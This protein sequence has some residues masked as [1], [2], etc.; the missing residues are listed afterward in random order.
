MST[1]KT[2]RLFIISGPSGVGK[3]SLLKRLLANHENLRFS[4]SSTTRQPRVGEI[5]GVDYLFV[6][7]QQFEEDIK[8][9]MFLEYAQVHNNFYGTS[10]K[11]IADM[12]NAGLDVILDIDVQGSQNLMNRKIE[13]IYIFI[14]P[15]SI[16]ELRKRLIGRA[17]DS[18]EVIATRVKNAET[19]MSFVDKYP[20]VVVNDNLDEAYMKLENIIYGGGQK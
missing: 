11:Q 8:N 9:D 1:D 14:A 18:A 2:G 5:D 7:K 15:P 13:G 4:V 20:N 12:T 16:D 6:T 10:K 17:T 3:S 19:E